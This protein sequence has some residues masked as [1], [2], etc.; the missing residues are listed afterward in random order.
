M[1]FGLFENYT[2]TDQPSAKRKKFPVLTVNKISNR[3]FDIV[4]AKVKEEGFYNITANPEYF[5]IYG[6][7]AGFELSIQI[8]ATGTKTIVEMSVYGEHRRGQT[9][10]FFKRYY[11]LFTSLLNE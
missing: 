4:L 9:R 2:S 5:D 8:C 10:K 11:H 1:L 3:V 6:E 7:K